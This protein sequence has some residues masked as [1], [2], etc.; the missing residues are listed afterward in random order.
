[1]FVRRTA[2]TGFSVRYGGGTSASGPLTRD[3][4]KLGGLKQYITFGRVTKETGEWLSTVDGIM[5]MA[6]KGLDCSP[7]CVEPMFGELVGDGV[8]A[9]VFALCMGDE[10]GWM[11]MGGI[12]QQFFSGP[13]FYTPIQSHYGTK[14]TFYN[15]PAKSAMP[16]LNP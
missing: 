6:F 12:D 7:T 2:T 9:D 3:V 13:I 16:R 5:G 1:M 10:K 11:T 4:I 8:V 15:I 14:Y